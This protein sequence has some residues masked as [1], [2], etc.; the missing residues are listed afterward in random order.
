MQTIKNFLST[1]PTV[2]W[3]IIAVIVLVAFW[4]ASDDVGSWWENR[5]QSQF[6]AKQIQYEQQIDTLK[7]QE[8]ELVKRAEIAEARE[9]TRIIEKDLLLAEIAKRGINIKDAEAKIQAATDEF[10]SELDY[11]QNED[12]SKSEKCNKQ[13]DESASMGYPCIPNKVKYCE[14]FKE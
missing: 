7:K 6:D 4:W 9:Q 2:V 1:I 12:I 8:A 11:I 10:A 13:C 5:K 14:K 3:V